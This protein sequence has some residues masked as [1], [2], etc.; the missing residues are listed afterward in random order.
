M[1]VPELVTAPLLPKSPWTTTVPPLLATVPLLRLTAP[2]TVIVPVA[3]FTKLAPPEIET[4]VPTASVPR[5]SSR[6]GPF[7]FTPCGKFAVPSFSS[8]NVPD[9]AMLGKVTVPR[10]KT[11]PAALLTYAGAS[12]AVAATQIAD[13]FGKALVPPV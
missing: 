11:A 9:T 3:V 13:P 2:L 4:P 5:L 7:V 12:V 1:K 10:L 8:R 6:A